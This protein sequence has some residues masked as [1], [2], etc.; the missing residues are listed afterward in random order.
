[1]FVIVLLQCDPHRFIYRSCVPRRSHTA[2]RTGAASTPCSKNVTIP[3]ACRCRRFPLASPSAAPRSRPTV[4]SYSTDTCRRCCRRTRPARIRYIST[5]RSSISMSRSRSSISISRSSSSS[6]AS[7]SAAPPSRPTANSFL[8]ATFRRCYKRTRPVRTRYV[9]AAAG[10]GLGLTRCC[11][12]LV[13]P[14]L[15]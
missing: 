8:I 6:V 3:P 11:N 13:N 9:A 10:V 7:L 4:S 14:N 5:S 2:T 1:M 15:L 12:Y